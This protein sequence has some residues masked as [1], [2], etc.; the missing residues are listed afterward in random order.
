MRRASL[1]ALRTDRHER[2]GAICRQ[3]KRHST[4]LRAA[5]LRR[6][7]AQEFQE[8]DRKLTTRGQ[9]PANHLRGPGMFRRPQGCCRKWLANHQ[10]CGGAQ[11]HPE[12]KP[13][14]CCDAL[15]DL[16]RHPQDPARRRL[17]SAS[18]RSCR[19]SHARSSSASL[20]HT[21]FAALSSSPSSTSFLLHLT[22]IHLHPPPGSF[23]SS[24]SPSTILLHTTPNPS[25][26]TRHQS[27]RAPSPGLAVFPRALHFSLTS[28]THPIVA[29]PSILS[30]RN[31]PTFPS[32]ANCLLHYRP[33]L[34][35]DTI[36]LIPSLHLHHANTRLE[37]TTPL[38]TSN[39][40]LLSL[41]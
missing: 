6:M 4:G 23:L 18:P 10:R 7:E 3:P 22:S 19:S 24:T 29:N 41:I 15:P 21:S 33:P 32:L 30:G 8:W 31:T 16:V 1:V 40:P 34:L 13:M 11:P 20:P 2:I 37:L 28:D 36:D 38:P 27:R 9:Q 17:S 25:R 14:G 12:P 35:P 39:S 5:E 26:L